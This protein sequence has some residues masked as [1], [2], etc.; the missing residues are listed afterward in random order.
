MKKNHKHHP[1]AVEPLNYLGELPFH[2]QKIT[3]EMIFAE[4]FQKK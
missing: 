4:I 2:V 1:D 3:E